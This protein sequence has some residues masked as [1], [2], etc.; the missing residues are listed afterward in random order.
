MPDFA[1]AWPADRLALAN[2]E[3]REVVIEHE[4]LSVLFTQPVHA[5]LIARGAQCRGH[6]RLRF[7]ALE[8]GGAVGPGQNADFA[9]D[10]PNLLGTAAINA[11]AFEDEV[12]NH[13]FLEHFEGTSNLLRGVLTLTV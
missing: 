3:R 9:S 2:A 6:Q 12:A 1:S 10:R 8:H 13:A 4:L 7:A 11:F 5:L